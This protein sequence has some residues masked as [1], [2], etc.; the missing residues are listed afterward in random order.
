MTNLCYKLLDKKNTEEFKKHTSKK[1]YKY[2]LIEVVKT[3]DFKVTDKIVEETF[4]ILD[5]VYFK[6]AI[7]KFIKE[8]RSTIS[9]SASTKLTKT[10]GFCKWKYWLDE[11]GDIDYGDYEIQISKKIIDNLFKDKK[12][13]SLKING[14]HCFDK[15]ECYVNLFQHEIIHLLISIF[16]LKDGQGMGGH[17]RVFRGLVLNLF[18]HTEYKHLLL[19]GDSIKNDK[20][21]K[22]N[23]TNIEIGDKI[24][25]KPFKGKILK[26]TVFKLTSKYVYFKL[27]NGKKYYL[28]FSLINKIIKKSNSKKIKLKDLTPE[29]VKKKLKKGMI[30]YVNLKGKL[31]KGKVVN[32]GEKRATII[33]DSC[34]K[35]YIPFK[36]INIK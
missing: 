2:L 13:K 32:I 16:C 25:S 15:L 21:I 34:E 26:G 20:E 14:L 35:W 4:N 33:F 19:E 30:V 31:K 27:S 22:Y 8:S 11:Y 36:M 7:S 9:F 29:Q 28:S 23:Q 5:K 12:T 17:T 18:G 24:E 10:A 6:N 3:R 1:I